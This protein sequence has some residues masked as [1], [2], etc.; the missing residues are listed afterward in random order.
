LTFRP[1][2]QE[3]LPG[4]TVTSARELQNVAQLGD[5]GSKTF[6]GN[7]AEHKVKTKR[8][9]EKATGWGTATVEEKKKDDL[10]FFGHVTL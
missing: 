8:K 9:D 5:F 10:L 3:E 1:G 6:W 7:T 4:N 2:K